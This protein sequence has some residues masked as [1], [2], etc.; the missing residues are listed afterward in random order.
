MGM[1]EGDLTIEDLL[2]PKTLLT[3][4]AG[5]CL[6]KP[7]NLKPLLL[8]RDYCN[9][10]VQYDKWWDRTAITR[11]KHDRL[12][13]ELRY[14]MTQYTFCFGEPRYPESTCKRLRENLEAYVRGARK[15]KARVEELIKEGENLEVRRRNF[16]HLMW[17]LSWM[18]SNLSWAI[19][20]ASKLMARVE[21]PIG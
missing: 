3:Y 10:L 14:L 5:Y 9:A 8:L 7:L 6:G 17:R 21:E 1:E 15:L 13:R 19:E 4:F 2:K 18:R 11:E 12:M 16:E 20:E